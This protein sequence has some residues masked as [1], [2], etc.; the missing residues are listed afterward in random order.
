[1]THIVETVTI[2][3]ND[4]SS[5]TYYKTEG[6]YYYHNCRRISKVFYEAAKAVPKARI[7]QY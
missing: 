1:M 5:H 7:R 4:G 6:G 2:I 3:W